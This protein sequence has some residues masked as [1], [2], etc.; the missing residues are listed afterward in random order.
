MGVS[1]MGGV[2]RLDLGNI[3]IISL[4]AF[5]GVWLIDRALNYAGLS[6]WNTQN[7]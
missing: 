6:A 7:A 3:I 2:I 4:A 1:K 5:T